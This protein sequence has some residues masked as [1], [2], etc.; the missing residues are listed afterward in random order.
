VNRTRDHF[1]A[2]PALAG[3]QHGHFGRG[4]ALDE[5]A[6]FHDRGMVPDEDSLDRKRSLVLREFRLERHPLNSLHNRR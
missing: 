4:D 1:F 2:G 6:Q 5:R 3:D